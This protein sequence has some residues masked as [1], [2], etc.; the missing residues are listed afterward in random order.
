MNA[1]PP[2]RRYSGL[3]PYGR[4]KDKTENHPSARIEDWLRMPGMG[5]Y[6]FFLELLAEDGSACF[7]LIERMFVICESCFIG[8]YV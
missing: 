5:I 8:R 2:A 7:V 4:N 3:V 1:L 6:E